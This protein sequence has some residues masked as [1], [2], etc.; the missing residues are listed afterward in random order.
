MTYAHLISKRDGLVEY[1]T[2]NRPDV[3]NAFNE[4]MIAELTD[5]AVSMR[6]QTANRSVRAAVLAGAGPTFSAGA[7]VNWMSKTIQYTEEQNI[8]DAM[9]MSGMFAA[10]NELPVPLV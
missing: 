2:L 9:A 1:L 7:D 4:H 5:W 10:I 8:R 6:E 3:R